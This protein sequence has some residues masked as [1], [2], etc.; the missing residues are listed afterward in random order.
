M[1]LT[2]DEFLSLPVK[3][4]AQ[5]VRKA[6]PKVCVFPINGTR[7]WFMLEHP[8]AADSIE[9]YL[10]I[11]GMRY[12]EVCK[13]LFDHGVDT[14][15]TPMFGPDLLERGEAYQKM[16]VPALMWFA[17]NKEFLSFHD[18]YDIRVRFYGDI[19]RYFANTP[20]APALEAYNRLTKQTANHQSYHLFIGICAHDATETVAEASVRFHQQNGRVPNKQE[21]IATYYGE[22]VNPVD[23]F[24]GFDRF[25]A[26]D[27]PLIA[28]GNEDLYFMVSPS[29]YIDAQTLRSILYDHLYTRQIDESS[30]VDLSKEN[31][32]KLKAFYHEN[33]RRVL[34]IGEKQ[35]GIWYPLM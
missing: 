33:R 25:T 34:G 29:M 26:F 1:N 30:Y 19:Q 32:G 16:M 18:T 35:H 21:I 20:Y 17:E 14:L 27:M 11:A 15:L 23:F 28:T 8:E 10:Q 13:L 24:I 5:L 3:K 4:V 7:R 9:S 2:R 22:H 6:G 31:W 12:I